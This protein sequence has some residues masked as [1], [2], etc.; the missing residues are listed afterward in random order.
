M[1]INCVGEEQLSSGVATSFE[2]THTVS[3][4]ERKEER[5]PPPPRMCCGSVLANQESRSLTKNED[6]DVLCVLCVD[7]QPLRQ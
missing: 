4:K 2:H 3:E 6:D 7:F 1:S 5:Q